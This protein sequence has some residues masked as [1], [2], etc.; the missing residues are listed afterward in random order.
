MS[1]LFEME[2][3][4]ET[5]AKEFA[6]DGIYEFV[7]TYYRGSRL[8]GRYRKLETLSVATEKKEVKN[9]VLYA[10][11]SANDI[12]Y[13]TG[14]RSPF[15]TFELSQAKKFTQSEAE[16]AKYWANKRGSYDWKVQRV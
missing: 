6:E 7:D 10:Y 14:K 15:T 13:Y 9:C 4:N 11:N 5:E 3:V 12:M 2:V 1:D 8:I 16:S